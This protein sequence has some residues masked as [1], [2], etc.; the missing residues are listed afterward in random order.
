[1]L[2]FRGKLRI[3]LA[4]RIA[5]KPVG[6]PTGQTDKGGDE[7]APEMTPSN[8]DDRQCLVHACCGPAPSLCTLHIFARI[9][10]ITTPQKFLNSI[11]GF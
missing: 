11:L 10:L 9:I 5:Q 1:M 3:F 7:A 6:R 8:T 2:I 4:L